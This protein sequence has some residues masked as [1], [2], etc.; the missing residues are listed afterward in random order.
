M[1]SLQFLNEFKRISQ[2]IHKYSSMNSLGFLNEFSRIAHQGWEK[3]PMGLT[4]LNWV[5]MGIMRKTQIS[6]TD[7]DLQNQIR[8]IRR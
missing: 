2:K 7:S 3:T 6:Y 8:K 4:G 5:L 1:N